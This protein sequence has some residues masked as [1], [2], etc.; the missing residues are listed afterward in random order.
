M[1]K[2]YWEYIK[3]KGAIKAKTNGIYLNTYK[4]MLKIKNLR[5]YP[6]TF[7]DVG[8]NRGMFTKTV[9]YIYP[10]CNIYSF[11]PIEACYFELKRLENT[12]STLKSFNCALSDYNGSAQFNESLYDYS[13][14]LLKMTEK[15]QSAFPYTKVKSVYKVDVHT[16]KYFSNKIKLI[17]P[18]IL[19]IDVQGA[20]LKVMDGAGEMLNIVD[21]ILCEVSFAKLYEG[22]PLVNEVINYMSKKGFILIDIVSL[23]RD[24]KNNE[25][26][27]AD[28]LFKRI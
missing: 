10:D 4:I 25:L 1:I 7:I 2:K 26:L 22:Q 17:A 28:G 9:N 16:F 18:T 23:N 19:K 20:E 15:H 21:Y 11:E 27:Q 24:P 8:A 5:I 14:S 13:S 3:T 6:N 12:I